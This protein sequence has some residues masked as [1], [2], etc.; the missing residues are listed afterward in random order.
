MANLKK[1]QKLVVNKVKY[2]SIQQFD[3]KHLHAVYSF[4]LKQLELIPDHVKKLHA[5]G[6]TDQEIIKL[7]Y[8]SWPTSHRALADKMQRKFGD[9]LAGVPGF[10]QDPHQGWQVAGRDG[11]AIPVRNR[12]G[13][14][15]GIKLRVDRPVRPSAKYVLLSTNPQPDSATGRSRYPHGT[16]AT[17]CVHWP[18]ERP[19]KIK[20]LRI[21]EGELKADICNSLINDGSYTIS[22]PGVNL[23]RMGIEAAE[24][25]GVKRVLLAFDSDKS[26]E[27]GGGY[28]DQITGQPLN[29]PFAVAKALANLFLNLAAKGFDVTI[30]DWPPDA[31][32]GID[33][34]LLNGCEDQ[35]TRLHGTEAEA[36]A[37]EQ[38]NRGLPEGWVYVVGTKTFIHST[39]LQCLDK[40]QFNDQFKSEYAKGSPSDIVLRNSAFPKF[41]APVFLPK[42]PIVVT[43]S[44]NG[45]CL[46]F[47]N[48]WRGQNSIHEVKRQPTIFLEHTEYLIP[49]QDDRRIFLDWLA[50]NVQHEGEKILWALLLQSVEGAGKSYYGKMLAMLLG[51]RNVGFPSNDEIHEIFT[52]WAK[53]KSLIIIEEIM[54]RGRQE[55]MNRL[56][57]IITQPTIEIR[58]MY[59]PAYR[60]KNIFNILMFT[61]HKDAVL[62]NR[63]DRR[64]CPIFS[65]AVK[66]DTQYYDKLFADLDKNIGSILFFLR[67]RDLSHFNPHANAPHSSSK[68]ELISGSRTPLQQWMAEMIENNMW[69]FHTDIVTVAHLKT[70]LPPELR[71]NSMKSIGDALR[72]VG[73]RQ[74]TKGPI[75][76]KTGGQARV[77]LVRRQDFW[78]EQTSDTIR[79]EYEKWSMSHEPGNPMLDAK[80]L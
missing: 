54:A 40:E 12:E 63:E 75:I 22:L 36:W 64:Y 20:A 67:R 37:Q 44:S 10:W 18:L 39:T 49:N 47:F 72:E 14:I 52:G 45:S 56:K 53:D 1:Q 80:P 21:T 26:K 74:W 35:I 68:D 78:E 25:I 15:V 79:S 7:G 31:G 9:K 13:H 16:K 6:L 43:D 8:K 29:E 51:E 42:Q 62:I 28:H 71:N 70:C 38:L 33:D 27:Q 3:P 19:K 57:S 60:Q 65:P 55:L 48:L 50:W 30:E 34:V 59:R 77:W 5:R 11:I 66:R 61:N 76:L 58:E 46:K 73:A 2:S 32:K 4:L 17:I 23:W 69:P 24:Q 41:A